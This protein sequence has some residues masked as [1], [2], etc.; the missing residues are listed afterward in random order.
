MMKGVFKL[1]AECY[2]DLMEQNYKDGFRLTTREII[3]KSLFPAGL[4][5][6][7]RHCSRHQS[8]LVKD[9]S[10]VKRTRAIP[11]EWFDV[12]D[13][14]GFHVCRACGEKLLTKKGKFSPVMRWCKREDEQHVAWV[15][16]VL[17][18]FPIRRD[19]YLYLLHKQQHEDPTNAGKKFY[20]ICEKCGRETSR[21][22]V[23]HKTPVSFL[24][25]ENVNLLFDHENFIALCPECHAGSH[26]W[27]AKGEVRARKNKEQHVS[28]DSFC[29]FDD[30]DKSIE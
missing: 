30:K 15:R 1:C 5:V 17:L 28:L 8:G 7:N 22:D 16:D 10:L 3:K 12:F 21:I 26:P 14:E 24:K 27:R 4:R 9:L 23:H 25:L 11:V 13:Q 19:E 2:A 18:S 20:L 6:W 29:L